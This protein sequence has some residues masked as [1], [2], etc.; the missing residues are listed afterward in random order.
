M[1]LLSLETSLKMNNNSASHQSLHKDILTTDHHHLEG[2]LKNHSL[3]GSSQSHPLSFEEEFSSE[4]SEVTG[5]VLISQFVDLK[6]DNLQSEA[7]FNETPISVE[8]VDGE[9]GKRISIP[10]SNDDSPGNSQVNLSSKNF[11]DN[12]IIGNQNAA[13][14]VPEASP[15]QNINSFDTLATSDV[16]NLEINIQPVGNDAGH[17]NDISLN[18]VEANHYINNSEVASNSTFNSQSILET[19][20]FED[21]AFTSQDSSEY[22]DPSVLPVQG[23]VTGGN[24]EGIL[25]NSEIESNPS[26]RHVGFKEI[27]NPTDAEQTWVIIHGWN[28]NP[29][30]RFTELAQEIATTNTGDRVLLLDWREA[31]F[32]STEML[33]IEYGALGTGNFRAAT[34]ID[35]VA[36][37]AVEAL[38][39]YYGID[40]VAASQSLNLV[41]HSLGSLVSAEIGKIYRDGLT[42]ENETVVTGNNEGARTITALDPPSVR[43]GGDNPFAVEPTEDIYDIDGRIEGIQTPE[44]YADASVFS[45]AYVGEKSIAGNKELALGADE[46]FEMDFGTESELTDFGSEHD[47]VVRAFTNTINQEGIIGDLLGIGAYE[48]LETIAI[49]DLGELQ[50]LEG[51]SKG[52]KGII[53][54]SEENLVTSL[55]GIL[56]SGNQDDIVIGSSGNQ[57][58]HGTDLLNFGG[59]SPYS[60]DHNDIFLGESGN[61]MIAGDDN[62]D[63][64]I[65]GIGKDILNGGAGIDTFIFQSGDGGATESDTNII[66]DFE[67]GIDKIG[68]TG[69]NFDQLTFQQL[70]SGLAG[71]ST[72]TVIMAGSEVIALLKNTKVE[73]V[74]HSEYFVGVAENQFQIS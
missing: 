62:D 32:N 10:V 54:V 20:S 17:V 71:N 52:F 39:D 65:G 3:T 8:F 42:V 64:L 27:S 7:A 66:E 74:Q 12:T 69:I 9:V 50:I 67:V 28:D 73:E 5:K 24:E 25:L 56:K 13:V 11:T 41:G 29:D 38:N 49:D 72:D 47:R 70:P 14:T 43:N 19:Q 57:E 59:D 37:F 18:Q 36:E 26:I 53:N 35:P 68:L 33:G 60:G 44:T 63:I 2:V 6:L 16:N 34:W 4:G 51:Y 30:D 31:A 21:A 1:N 15:H 58:M 40:S 46:A 55:A 23:T 45:R 61:D 22:L 48:S